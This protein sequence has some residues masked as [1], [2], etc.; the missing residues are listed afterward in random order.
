MSGEITRESPDDG[1][2]WSCYRSLARFSSLELTE[3]GQ[4]ESC[5]DP[6][7]WGNIG[8]NWS[9]MR[10]NHAQGCRLCGALD[11]ARVYAPSAGKISPRFLHELEGPAQEHREAGADRD[12]ARLCPGAG[13]AMHLLS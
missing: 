7:P 13:R 8:T 3:S 2:G 6:V 5:H 11:Y 12:D 4:A 10:D 1:I 9:L